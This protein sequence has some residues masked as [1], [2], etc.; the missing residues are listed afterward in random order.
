MV[1]GNFLHIYQPP[2]QHKD[3][4]RKIT[5][6]SYYK[7]VEILEK[8]P[9]GKLTLNICACLTEQLLK[10]GYKDLIE[11]IKN[12]LEKGQIE[13]T[14]SSKYHAFLP[15]LPESEIKRQIILNQ[16]THKKI[17]G[18]N[19]KPRGIHLPE[20]A[21]AKKIAK[22]VKK[23]G[24]QW[25][26]LNEISFEGKLF[27]K[28]DCSQI[29]KHKE[30]PEIKILFRNRK[31]SDLIQRGFLWKTEDFYQFIKE[32]VKAEEYIITAMDG[33]T[34]GHH[35]PGLEKLLEKIYQEKKIKTMTIS[36][37]VDSFPEGKEIEPIEGSWASMESEIKAKI[38]YAQWKYPK[39]PIHQRQWKLT[40]LAIDVVNKSQKD[41]GYK[42]ARK[43]LDEALFSCQY[44]W[45]GAVPWWEIEYIEKGAYYLKKS[46]ESLNKISKKTKKL[47]QDLYQEIVSLAFEWERSGLAHKKSME[48]TK[49]I[50]KELGEK[51][52]EPSPLHSK[53]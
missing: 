13:L 24:Y 1:W 41:P 2:D 48:Y 20:M 3:L 6:E 22:V 25:M 14:E 29:Y 28:I 33:E 36:E 46:I 43:I 37:I 30:F 51:I 26:V 49:K 9:E 16:K 44:W 32:N 40:N 31:L 18:K 35:R 27:S 8:N 47:A 15:L 12:L 34:F 39:H 38:P 45:A 4:L 10:L 11:R 53:K 7:I 52:P 19:Y 50:I 23:L 5:E 42:K 21:Y 17:F